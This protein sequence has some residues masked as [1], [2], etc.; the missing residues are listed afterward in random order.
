VATTPRRAQRKD[1]SRNRELLLTAAQKVFA[2][3]GPE[4]AL[5]EVA[6]TA[7]VSRMTLYRNFATRDELVATVFQ[8]NVTHIEQRARELAGA[9]D[10]AVTLFHEVLSM[11]LE[12]KGLA[13]LMSAH[14]ESGWV[15]ELS[16]RTAAAFTPL[17]DTGRAAGIVWR[18]IGPADVLLTLHMADASLT[19]SDGREP[20]EVKRRVHRM[21][22]R[23]LFTTRL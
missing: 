5:E 12:N 15:A 2:E 9:L 3:H 13:Y 11:Q 4:V 20:I 6:R 16:T 19:A 10:G 18:E 1:A 22:H 23:A 17:L 7:G 21:L 14:A 8:D